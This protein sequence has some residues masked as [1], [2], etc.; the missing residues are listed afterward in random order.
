[1]RQLQVDTGNP[2]RAIQQLLEATMIEVE[3]MREAIKLME[4]PVP[5]WKI[6]KLA[7]MHTQTL[8]VDLLKLRNDHIDVCARLKELGY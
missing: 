5:Q 6:R 1:M 3:A 7:E 2:M 4:V 8:S